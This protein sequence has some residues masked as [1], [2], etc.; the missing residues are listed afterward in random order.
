VS[1]GAGSAD[2]RPTAVALRALGLGDFL[3]GL[4]ALR[5][6]RTALPEHRLILVAPETFRPL[7]ELGAVADEL[8]DGHEL[9][10][11][12]G[13]DGPV[14]VAVDLHGNGPGSRVLLEALEPRRVVG[15]GHPPSGRPGPRWR[16][17]EHEVQRWCRL[18]TESFPGTSGPTDVAGCLPV[19]DRAAP[20]GVCVVHPGAAAPSRRWPAERFA[21]VVRFL[22]ADGHRVVVTGGPAEQRLTAEVAG[23]SGAEAR[24]EMSLLQLLALVAS[25]R[26]VV[27]GDTGVAHVASAYR[28]PSVVLFGPV[29]PRVWGP[30]PD[31]PHWVLWH[32]DGTGDPHGAAVDPALADIS[33]AEV[34]DAIAAQL[35]DESAG[36]R[37]P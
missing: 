20:R 3:T 22:R 2:G 9:A 27:S 31:G 25:A 32:G 30:P 36:T 5:L 8:V 14:E 34:Q 16:R 7:V 13:V 15:F 37:G 18:V 6:L 12:T 11:I 24:T 10:P 35:A 26:L 21:D 23:A 19:P 29:S 33:V 17:H 4:P 28:T 1:C